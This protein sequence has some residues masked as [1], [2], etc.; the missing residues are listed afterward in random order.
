GK[1]DLDL[2]SAFW[3]NISV[4]SQGWEAEIVE[5]PGLIF[6]LQFHRLSGLTSEERWL[7]VVVVGLQVYLSFAAYVLCAVVRGRSIAGR[8]PLSP[9]LRHHRRVRRPSRWDCGSGT[10]ARL[11]DELAWG[12]ADWHSCC[13]RM[14]HEIHH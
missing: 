14:V 4:E 12:V 1:G 13:D 11:H 10:R 9:G 8:D 7:E 3:R 5:R 2:H 6:D